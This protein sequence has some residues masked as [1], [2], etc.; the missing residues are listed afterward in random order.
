MNENE[1]KKEFPSVPKEEGK[2]IASKGGKAAH[3]QG[4]DH[5]ANSEE[6]KEEGQSPHK[7]G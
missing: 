4:A 2:D 6:T 5:E 3:E 7:N 1:T